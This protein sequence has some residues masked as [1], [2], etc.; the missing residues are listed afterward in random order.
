MAAA[1]SGQPFEFDIRLDPLLVHENGEDDEEIEDH[2]TVYQC[3]QKK[4]L[5]TKCF[6]RYGNVRVVKI[7]EELRITLSVSSLEEFEEIKKVVDKGELT[8][9]ITDFAVSLGLE[10]ELGVF[11]HRGQ[12][13]PVK[14]DVDLFD[15]KRTIKKAKSHFKNSPKPEK[16]VST[17]LSRPEEMT[18]TTKSQD[19]SS[20]SVQIIFDIPF[21]H[22]T[23]YAVFVEYTFDKQRYRWAN[24]LHIGDY[25]WMSSAISVPADVSQLLYRCRIKKYIWTPAI[26]YFTYIVENKSYRK[27]NKI[28]SI[29]RD[30]FDTSTKGI[31]IG[32][33]H[34]VQHLLRIVDSSSLKDIIMQTDD[35]HSLAQSYISSSSHPNSLNTKKV[36]KILEVYMRNVKCEMWE[37][38]LLFGYVCSLLVSSDTLH[39]T[40]CEKL[41][42]ISRTTSL[43][44]LE[45]FNNVK[46]SDLP[47]GSMKIL[48][49]IVNELCF[50][51]FP[52]KSSHIVNMLKYC[53]PAFG[54]IFMM[55][56]FGYAGNLPIS[57]DLLTCEH[58]CEKILKQKEFGDAGA[59]DLFLKF[60]RH[61]PIDC[62]MELLYKLNESNSLPRS[63][64]LNAFH[65]VLV[66]CKKS[67]R[68]RRF[69][70]LH[71]RVEC[72][73][74]KPKV[75]LEMSQ[76]LE[77]TVTDIIG[78]LNKS[79]SADIDT[80]IKIIESP[81]LFKLPASY[82][83]LY[84]MIAASENASIHR[85]FLKTLEKKNTTDM[86]E[87]MISKLVMKWFET[88]I[89]KHC[90][91]KQHKN[92]FDDLPFVYKHLDLLLKTP[93]VLKKENLASALKKETFSFLCSIPVKE[94]IEV[95][96]TKRYT[97]FELPDVFSE[98]LMRLCSESGEKENILTAIGTSSIG[99]AF[100]AATW[101]FTQLLMVAM[102][103]SGLSEAETEVD[104]LRLMLKNGL[105]WVKLMN[106]QGVLS[107][108]VKNREVFVEAHNLLESFTRDLVNKAVEHPP[109]D[110][111]S[112]CP[113]EP[114]S[115][116]FG[117]DSDPEDNYDHR[118]DHFPTS[119]L[120]VLK[121]LNSEGIDKY[122][123]AWR[124]LF[125]GDDCNIS[126]VKKI[127][128]IPSLETEIKC[129]EQILKKK[130]PTWL[131]D[132]MKMYTEYGIYEEKVL[133]VEKIL[134]ILNTNENV[135]INFC[136]AVESFYALK[137]STSHA[138]TL[139]QLSETKE[140]LSYIHKIIVG[141]FFDVL[142]ELSKASSLVEFLRETVEE[143]LR[144]LIDSVEE[145]SEQFIQESTIS[146]LI[147][148]RRFVSPILKL[149]N[150]SRVET[151]L[152]TLEKS[153]NVNQIK[154]LALKINECNANIHNLRSL[155][156]YCSNKVQKQ[157]IK[158]IGSKTELE[159]MRSRALLLVNTETKRPENGKEK[160]QLQEDLNL[161]IDALDNVMCIADW[162][163]KLAK[164]GHP[165]YVSRIHKA[166]YSRSDLKAEIEHLEQ[167]FEEW[168]MILDE[169][170]KKYYWLN[171]FYPEQLFKIKNCLKDGSY[172]EEVATLFEY[173]GCGT[174]CLDKVRTSFETIAERQDD[175]SNSLHLVGQT[176][177]VALKDVQF[178]P[179]C[180]KIDSGE[181]M[182]CQWNI[183]DVVQ[184]GQLFVAALEE[185]SKQVIPTVLAIYRNTTGFL[186]MPHQIL[187]C[188]NDTKWEHLHLL[189]QRCLLSQE[190][191]LKKQLFCIVG[192]EKL[193]NEVQFKLV[194]ELKKMLHTNRAYLAIT[195]E[196]STH[197]PFLDHFDSYVHHVQPMTPS[198]I[199]LCFR[200]LWPNI[201]TITSELPG[202]G[203]TELIHDMAD[204]LDMGVCSFHISGDIDIK[205]LIVR[206]SK[207]KLMPHDVLHI[208]IGM[209]SK[210]SDLD[211]LLFQLIILGF[212]VD[213]SSLYKLPTQHI[214]I[215]IANSINNVLR[216]SLQTTMFFCRK[217]LKWENFKKFK[218][219]KEICSSVQVVCCYLNKR[220]Q[221]MLDKD[222]LYFSGKN[223]AKCLSTHKCQYLLQKHFSSNNDLSFSIVNIFLSVLADQLKKMSCSLFFRSSNLLAMLGNEEINSVK[224]SLMRGLL[225]FSGEFSMRS[226]ET[227][228]SDQ[229]ANVSQMN[230]V[231][232]ESFSTCT[233]ANSMIKRVESM[234]QWAESNHLIVAFHNSDIQTL[235]AL[236]RD[237]ELVPKH[238]KYL[239]ERQVGKQL[240]DFSS[241]DQKQLQEILKRVARS[242]P[243]ELPQET[244]DKLGHDYALT[245]DNLLKMILIIIRIKAHV[246]V[247]I[248]GETGCGKTSLI[249]YLAMI[250]DVDLQ[251]QNIHAGTDESTIITSVMDANAKARSNLEEPVWMFLDEIN[252]CNHLGL[253]NNIICHHRCQEVFL[254]PNLVL[255]A[256]CN[257]YKLRNEDSI[258]TAGL[259]MKVK[260]D[261]QSKLVYRVNPLPETMVDFVWDYG[262][263]TCEDEKE[264]IQRM[265]GDIVTDYF[266]RLLVELLVMSQN[267]IKE[268][269]QNE[270]SVSLRDVSRCKRLICWFKGTLKKKYPELRK[271][272]CEI[273]S[274]ILA[275]A[276]SYHSRLVKT[277]E[278]L[279]YREE[280]LELFMEHDVNELTSADDILDII[281]NEQNDI[282]RRMC[283][284]QGIA[285]NTALQENVF[286]IM[287]C[288]L[289]HIPIFVVGKP[290]CSKSLSLQLIR[291]NLRGKDSEDEYFQSLPQ[292]YF[293]SYQGS[294][295]STSDGII[296]VFDKAKRYR[297]HNQESDVLPVVILDE[298]GLAEVS[299]FNPLKV[300]HSLLEPG[301][302]E[303]PDVAVVGISNWAL[304]AAKMNRAIHLSRPD[305]DAEELYRTGKSISEGSKNDDNLS[306]VDLVLLKAIAYAY[307]SYIE[308]Q[309]FPNFH[310]LRDYYSL[311]KYVSSEFSKLKSNE[312]NP[313]HEGN[314]VLRGL[315]RNFGGLPSE[316]SSVVEVY[317]EE[318]GKKD[319]DIV[320]LIKENINDS[321]AR[322]LL[323]STFGDSALSIIENV[324]QDMDREYELIMGSQ[325]EEDLTDDYNYRILSRIILCMEQGIVLIL[326]DLDSI[327]GS[328]YDMLNQN[329]TI[330]GRK[331]NCRI[332]HGAYGNPL[333]HVDD[334]FRCIVLVEESK[335]YRSDPPFLNR[336][337][338]Q[339]VCLA[340]ILTVEDL[341]LVNEMDTWL[342]KITSVMGVSF[343]KSDFVPIFTSD[344][345]ASLVHHILTI[346]N[347]IVLTDQG[348]NDLSKMLTKCKDVLL[349][350]CTPDGIIRMEKSIFAQ[351][352]NWERRELKEKYFNLPLHAGL[353]F[354]IQHVLQNQSDE[355]L[356][357]MVFTHSNI[358][359]DMEA[360]LKSVSPQCQ[361]ESLSSFKSEKQLSKRIGHFWKDSDHEWL[362]IQCS[363]HKDI[364]NFLLMKS[365]VEKH[366]TEFVHTKA[367]MKHVVIIIHLER[368]VRNITFGCVNFLSSWQLAFVD[369]VD[370]CPW[371]VKSL[372]DKTMEEVIKEQRPL[373][374]FITRYLFWAF[375]C[376]GYSNGYRTVAHLR[377]IIDRLL[378]NEELLGLLEELT[379]QFVNEK[380]SIEMSKGNWQLDV[381]CNT[382]KLFKAS[383]LHGA[384]EQEIDDYLK[385]SLAALV[386]QLELKNAW[387]VFVAAADKK[388]V[389]RRNNPVS[390]KGT[391]PV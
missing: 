380:A 114:S 251:V 389:L 133:I 107:K 314:I 138:I 194:D 374:S 267:F 203:K 37:V 151:I 120:S 93:Y 329:Y 31:E 187:F 8:K 100:D 325:F 89:K 96:C 191:M 258:L 197:H 357:L 310:G 196:G 91:E 355:C 227:C 292:L 146:A 127:L 142:K 85:L 291:S 45:S 364:K 271:R 43:A 262:N 228:R 266:V 2:R 80:L 19:T 54:S 122:E 126:E 324:L 48:E 351:K 248:M 371:P 297:E 220:E 153:A 293:V 304:D 75:I 352:N 230:S 17:E 90:C 178:K 6:Q 99:D 147:D 269:L 14:L 233:S 167:I 382:Y 55:T 204:D 67:S 323:L 50:I 332:A 156:K 83:N 56:C 164:C 12:S 169:N 182:E 15:E 3:L 59:A 378:S 300:L 245:P 20:V 246:P 222:D 160:A 303:V 30:V 86:S 130:L 53:Y 143:D 7:S 376:I 64:L 183:S 334:K 185:N 34:H 112:V 255:M 36:L 41:Q 1:S 356:K 327:Y 353:A 115:K 211:F 250:C 47:S 116:L 259:T 71:K 148:V 201:V 260:T 35:L 370:I 341:K 198:A 361:I 66:D 132:A 283:L 117:E 308:K 295:S 180:F 349:H 311:V 21:E 125:S 176:L 243:G 210:P 162:F 179:K 161:F 216:N 158:T 221:G 383:T 280:M 302:S 9:S 254:A 137:K 315:M 290:G 288:I 350:I 177:E 287:V 11:P 294:E 82:D 286:V 208:D 134:S 307:Q 365:I 215:E 72:L 249:R 76:V 98:H 27:A 51:V 213:G 252:T 238:I 360:C 214:S 70:A 172:S 170:R 94:L 285:R 65:S 372:L 171:C 298:I 135:D 390:C 343:S 102:D 232:N 103:L 111:K 136:R 375:T 205:E 61:S 186:P 354:Y 275:L 368:E 384:L 219:R 149:T 29:I 5:L 316:V 129:A 333:C 77:Q 279:Q 387:D 274:I 363:A 359:T 60:L 379:V 388:E 121:V 95:I 181:T 347:D 57:C 328:L 391:V 192:V 150:N 235:S 163:E 256:A 139:K 140:Q 4:H 49:K 263:L 159:D 319:I 168:T 190:P 217:Q 52:E 188:H 165:D 10:V 244:V 42:T 257:P 97:Q 306:S 206:M 145:H 119:I 32:F 88:A 335:L 110:L 212:L 78:V 326:K 339:N 296:K 336:F 381:V 342:S 44:I 369:K 270:S 113:E 337:E 242:K 226:L 79:D 175:L 199:E 321:G 318:L 25:L 345:L 236:Y 128:D 23:V 289:N 18:K 247:I 40:T 277:D 141:D 305:M 123:A 24:L 104:K 253:I 108:E 84:M 340:N 155:Y 348:D 154:S 346:E 63:E 62:S 157:G 58:I 276:H 74:S 166:T 362:I 33:A 261:E 312:K 224:S 284:P 299:R 39:T 273:N 193:I 131:R 16:K 13:S 144:Q 218:I 118:H 174:G 87:E 195:C 223:T 338:K 301:D 152:K 367:H 330:V 281:D 265:V 366:R 231:S 313:I 320:S 386:Y 317:K 200:Q 229:V 377:D 22:K 184:K 331:K 81:V 106:V 173:G 240:P 28:T 264:Y 225:E 309:R 109:D 26:Y 239:F 189:L 101:S 373:T 272:K 344:M 124:P 241:L 322:H 38:F 385:P 73:A 92:K 202:Q 268:R 237:K 209:V 68:Q 46:C 278:R 282:L 207:L 69:E 105:F 234:I 358:H